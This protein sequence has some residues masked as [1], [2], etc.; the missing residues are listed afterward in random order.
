MDL[1]RIRNYAALIAIVGINVQKGQEVDITSEV[2]Q[3]DFVRIL[4]EE[5]YKA[6]AGKVNLNWTDTAITRLD[7]EYADVENL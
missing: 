3:M 2:E 7:I 1:N 6:G 5:V 4:V